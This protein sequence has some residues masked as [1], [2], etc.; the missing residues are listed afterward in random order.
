[1]A[2]DRVLAQSVPETS[3]AQVQR[4]WEEVA[5]QAVAGSA[6]PVGERSGEILVECESATW[7]AELSMMSEQLLAGLRAALPGVEIERMRFVTGGRRHPSKPG[8]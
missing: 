1:L 5:G 3:L 2:V 6:S 7:A 8:F 4:V